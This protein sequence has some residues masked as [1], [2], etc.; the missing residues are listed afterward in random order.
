MN[1]Q[2][3]LL[4]MLLL[5][6]V[7][8]ASTRQIETSSPRPRILPDESRAEVFGMGLLSI[9]LE[10]GATPLPADVQALRFRLEEVQLHTDEGEWL[11]FP[12]ELNTFEILPDRY[13]SKTILTTRVQPLVYDSI[14]IK[15]TDTFVLFGENAGGPLASPDDEALKIAVRMQPEVGQA[16]QISITLEPGASLY[17]DT[18]CRWFFVPF[19]TGE[20]EQK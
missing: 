10:T 12:A 16:T 7:G 20:E 8:C 11:T 6:S 1:Y 19:W 3:Y 14:A 18:E 5:V 13:L 15:I 4:L 9:D 2:N 17:R